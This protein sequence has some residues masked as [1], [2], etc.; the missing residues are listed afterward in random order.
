MPHTVFEAHPTPLRVDLILFL[1]SGPENRPNLPSVGSAANGWLQLNIEFYGV[2]Q[3]YSI[4]DPWECRKV[5]QN[6]F[7]YVKDCG[8]CVNSGDDVI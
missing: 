4:L 7:Y 6:I 2:S 8:L 1:L 5:V 3:F